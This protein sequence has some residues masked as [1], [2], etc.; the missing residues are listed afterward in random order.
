VATRV[1]VNLVAAESGRVTVED[2][3]TGRH[4]HLACDAVLL[5]TARSPEDAL[6]LALRERE[7]EWRDAGILTVDCIGDAQCPGMI[8]HAVY[9]GHRHA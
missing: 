3:W 5:V 2:V 1:S 4:E 8:V 6:Y 9:A 7:P